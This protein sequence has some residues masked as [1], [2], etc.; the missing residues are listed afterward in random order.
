MSVKM[1]LVIKG[2]KAPCRTCVGRK[3][4]YMKV[5]SLNSS[6]A[7]EHAEGDD[8]VHHVI[9]ILGGALH[10]GESSCHILALISASTAI[11]MAYYFHIRVHCN[12]KL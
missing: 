9:K 8:A 6:I 12:F 5:E 7:G 11:I 2:V 10:G 1:I 3:G 4:M